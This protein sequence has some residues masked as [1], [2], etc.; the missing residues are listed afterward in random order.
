MDLR[1]ASLKAVSLYFLHN[2]STLNQCRKF[3][4]VTVV[5]KHLWNKEDRLQEPSRSVAVLTKILFSQDKTIYVFN[6]VKYATCFG[7]K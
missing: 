6:N 5:C 1:L 7:Y 4:C 3:F 2:V